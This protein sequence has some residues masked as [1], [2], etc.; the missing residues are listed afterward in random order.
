MFYS[1]LVSY[2]IDYSKGK[3][4]TNVIFCSRKKIIVRITTMIWNI[5]ELFYLSLQLEK[6]FFFNF[7]VGWKK[8]CE[9]IQSDKRKFKQKTSENSLLFSTKSMF[10][11]DDKIDQSFN[12]FKCRL[13]RKISFDIFEVIAEFLCY[14]TTI[15]HL[16]FNDQ[17]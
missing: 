14:S 15:N 16:S 17:T 1:I 5:L 6:I 7:L 3:R 11:H 4:S 8:K 10:W 12:I 2:F 13:S 9:S